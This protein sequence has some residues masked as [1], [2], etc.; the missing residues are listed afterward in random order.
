VTLCNSQLVC[1][2]AVLKRIVQG[3]SGRKAAAGVAIRPVPSAI[4][5]L[6]SSVGTGAPASTTAL[7]L[8]HLAN[9]ASVLPAVSLAI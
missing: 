9:A 1:S 2:E 6:R 3:I 5:D 8:H 4:W 7:H